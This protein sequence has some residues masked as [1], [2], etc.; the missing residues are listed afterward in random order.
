[1]MKPLNIARKKLAFIHTIFRFMFTSKKL[2]AGFLM[3]VPII[4]CGLFAP[5]IAIYPIKFG[6]FEREQP[7]SWEHPLGTDRYGRDVFSMLIYG[8]RASLMV[9]AVTGSIV[10]L[11]GVTL[12]CIAGYKGGLAAEF[13]KRIIDI[14]LVLPLLPLLFVIAAAMVRVRFTYFSLALFMAIFGWSGSARNFMSIVLSLRE[15]KFVD[16]AKLSN[17]SELEILFKEI[18]PNMLP[19]IATS[20]AMNVGWAMVTETGISLIGLGPSNANSLGTM[21]YWSRM[22][23]SIVRGIWWSFIPPSLVLIVFFVG[24]ILIVT[25]LDEVFN[26][27]LR[28]ITGW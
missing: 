25:G 2:V 18:I 22:S 12:G 11:I 13:L 21:I 15:S 6:M 4:F 24:L 28:R 8:I 17:E 3:V 16:L 5:W 10:T 14:F 23:A 20:F 7:P 1:M 27:R 9:G 26:P 19:F